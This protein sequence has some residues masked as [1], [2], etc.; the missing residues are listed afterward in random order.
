VYDDQAYVRGG[1][2]VS[3]LPDGALIRLAGD[4]KPFRGLSLPTHKAL[5]IGRL[6]KERDNTWALHDGLAAG[7]AT[8]KD[9][10]QTFRY[11][12]FCTGAGLDTLYQSIS[13]YVT[14]NADVLASGENNPATTCDS[15]SFGFGFEAAQVTPGGP[16]PLPAQLECCP[17]G[18]SS[19]EC[20][21]LC[22]DGKLSAGE[23]CD[24]AIA[25]GAPGACPKQCASPDPCRPRELVGE[26]CDARCVERTITVAKNADGCC[27]PGTATNADSDCTAVCGNNI[28]EQG[29]SCDPQSSCGKCET[30]DPCLHSSLTGA[31]ASCNV[32]CSWTATASCSAGDKCCPPGCN[33]GNDSDCPTQCG[34]GKVDTNAGE[35]CE[36]NSDKPCQTSCDDQNACT[37][38]LM[39]GSA[40]NCN[41]RCT[42]IPITK[43]APGDGCCPSGA[44]KDM[45]ADCNPQCGNKVLEAGETCDDGNTTSGDGCD[46]TCQREMVSA[47]CQAAVPDG[48]AEC[49]RCVCTRCADLA[50]TCYTGNDAKTNKECADVVACARKNRCQGAAC[51]CGGDLLGCSLGNPTGPCRK[52]VEAAAHTNSATTVAT[53]ANDKSYPIGRAGALGECSWN[54]CARE[55]G[56]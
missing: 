19:D 9:I 39:T 28:I 35:T 17:P 49:G 20:M 21:Q 50:L 12:G 51:Y 10:M 48:N 55:C 37:Q 25:Q 14:D 33:P 44:T 47:A 7:R 45:D 43:R 8:T 56:L 5:W 4:G 46:K 26:G 54:S 34:D 2:L 36:A 1:Y 13:N 52:E 6:S 18:K 29:E 24:T 30:S 15:L 40:G 41:V 23:S 32:E 22:G 27:L 16:K 38:D 53:R 3:Q 11:S 31:A 42:H